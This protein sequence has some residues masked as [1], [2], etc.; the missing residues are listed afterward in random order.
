MRFLVHGLRVVHAHGLGVLVELVLHLLTHGEGTRQGDL[1]Q[2]ICIGAQE[3][4][5]AQLDG[6][7][8]PDLADDAR[9]G[10]PIACPVDDHCRILVVDAFQCR[11]ETVGVAFAAH[12]AVGDD[13]DAGAL[14]VAYG[15]EGG[16][17]LGLLEPRLRN[18]PQLL[19]ARARH[20]L[21]QHVAVHQPVWLRVGADDGGL[22]ERFAHGEIPFL[23]K[24]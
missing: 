21:A 10:R 2:A 8:A 23:S 19:Q 16:V 17:V 6:A 11:G 5:V 9:Y 15:D 20:D 3:L 18:P 7:R 22:Q 12:L 24:L 1:C 13:V 14:H 4:H